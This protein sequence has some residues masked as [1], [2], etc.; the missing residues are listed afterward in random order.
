MHSNYSNNRS[1]RIGLP[2]SPASTRLKRDH[3]KEGHGR[4]PSQPIP[5]SSV[6]T[7]HSHRSLASLSASSRGAPPIPPVPDIRGGPY[8]AGLAR[9]RTH[10]GSWEHRD[11]GHSSP[12][13]ST[14]STAASSFLDRM[15]GW[16][17]EDSSRSSL[18]DDPKSQGRPSPRGSDVMVSNGDHSS[19][20][21]VYR[22]HKSDLPGYGG[23]I[24]DR[25][26][27]AAGVLTVNVNQAWSAKIAT[28]SGEETPP[29]HQSRLTRAMRAYHLAKAQ[30]PADLPD[31]LFD[32]HERRPTLHSRFAGLQV[33]SSME[34]SPKQRKPGLSHIYCEAATTS[35]PIT[36]RAT[37]SQ[38][39]V[40]ERTTPS[41]ATDRLRALRDAKRA[42]LGVRHIPVQPDNSSSPQG[43]AV[44]IKSRGD[45]YRSATPSQTRRPFHA[46]L[47]PK[48]GAF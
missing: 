45:Q 22:E 32:E 2:S 13:D 12:T 3:F 48:P 4:N 46:H 14:A 27:T 5:S 7:L 30:H 36:Q 38:T 33:G 37:Q 26:A 9:G 18:E 44:R 35:S 31:W 20:G 42:D 40:N 8:S 41:K 25:M 47:P 15:R 43:G 34:E 19:G 29:G 28:L 21:V 1:G 6:Q 24:W 17:S 16:P 10:V 39:P 11:S 23:S